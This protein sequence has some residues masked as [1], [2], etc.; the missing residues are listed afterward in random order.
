MMKKTF[1][2]AV[3]KALDQ[4]RAIPAEILTGPELQHLPL[5]VQRYLRITGCIGKEK[6]RNFRAEFMGGFRSHSLEKFSPLHSVQYNFFH[7]PTRIFYMVAKKMGIPAAGLHIYQGQT[8]SM[9]IKALGLFKVTDARGPE[10][11][12]GETVTLFNDMCFI[13]PATLVDKNIIWEEMGNKSVRARFKNGNIYV[14]ATLLFR[15]N[16][17]LEN[18]ISNDRYETTDGKTYNNYQWSTPVTEYREINNYYLPSAAKLI[19]K[20]PDGDFCYAEFKLR[21]LEY[22]CTEYT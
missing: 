2:T 4:T 21:R 22:N 9:V 17:E 6:V 19:F 18:F 3:L 11:N 14:S 16:G 13:A 10:M 1:K 5:I 12:Q 20:H 7:E 15:E 8:A